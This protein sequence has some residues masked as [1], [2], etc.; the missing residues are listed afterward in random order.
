MNIDEMAAGSEM[1]AL[2][3]ETVMGWTIERRQVVDLA[4]LNKAARHIT[5]YDVTDDHGVKWSTC[6]NLDAVGMPNYSTDIAAAWE[7]VKALQSLDFI[8]RLWS[9]NRQ[10][11]PHIP[12]QTWQVS[13]WKQMSKTT[14]DLYD[15]NEPWEN[16]YEISVW[17]RA[18]T[19]WLAICRAALKAVSPSVVK[20]QP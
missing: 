4:N 12:A 15:F 1:D 14:G 2:V 11:R 16:G 7:V 10:G 3:A 19:P 5:Q 20:E 13:A 18:D 6:C 17:G 9:P 8:V